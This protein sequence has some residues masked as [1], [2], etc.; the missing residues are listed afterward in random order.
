MICYYSK[1]TMCVRVCIESKQKIICLQFLDISFKTRYL[2]KN[3]Q[4][5]VNIPG[6]WSIHWHCQFFFL[7]QSNPMK[8]CG[9]EDE[10]KC[11]ISYNVTRIWHS[12]RMLVW[13]EYK[14]YKIKWKYTVTTTTT[15]KMP[16]YWSIVECVI[17]ASKLYH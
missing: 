11:Y 15:K 1:L 5:C 13:A 2:D 16:V 17:A 7:I 8:R 9:R 4:W 12:H 6:N 3:N 14:C 10:E